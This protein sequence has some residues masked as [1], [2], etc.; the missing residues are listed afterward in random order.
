MY[1][2]AEINEGVMM[3]ETAR[4]PVTVV[5]LRF[6][7]PPVR[8]V[9]EPVVASIEVPSVMTM[10]LLNRARIERAAL[11]DAFSVDPRDWR[12]REASD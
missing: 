11:S 6:V 3:P 9:N 7:V 12:R 10:P 1:E 8:L 5:A 4:S 2:V